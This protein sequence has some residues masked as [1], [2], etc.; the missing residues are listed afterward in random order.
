MGSAI[1]LIKTKALSSFVTDG[2]FCPSPR[3]ANLTMLAFSESEAI[4]I[5]HY[6][7]PGCLCLAFL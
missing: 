6:C 7:D 3:G 4:S 1:Q 2:L 5:C